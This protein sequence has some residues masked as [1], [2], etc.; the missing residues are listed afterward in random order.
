MKKLNQMVHQ[1]VEKTGFVS[2][3]SSNLYLNHDMRQ[4]N[5]DMDVANFVKALRW[6]K[7]S[8]DGGYG[9]ISKLFVFQNGK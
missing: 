7:L 8:I 3:V 5:L 6:K 4:N 2:P 1:W 9:K